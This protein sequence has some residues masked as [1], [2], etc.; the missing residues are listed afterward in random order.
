MISNKIKNINKKNI[1]IAF[2]IIV[3]TLISYIHIKNNYLQIFK[4]HNEKNSQVIS[5]KSGDSIRR[6]LSFD[7]GDIVEKIYVFPLENKNSNNITIRVHDN[8]KE[9]FKREYHTWP[10]NQIIVNTELRKCKELFIEIENNGNNDIDLYSIENNGSKTFSITSYLKVP[11]IIKNIVIISLVVICIFVIYLL[12]NVN[13]KSAEKIFLTI[14]IPFGL[15]YMLF[16]PP[17]TVP[18]EEAHIRNTLKYSS[19]LVGKG[20]EENLVVRNSEAYTGAIRPSIKSIEKFL[21]IN[22]LFDVNSEYIET[23]ID[24]GE[25]FKMITYLPGIIGVTLAR[26]ISLNGLLTIYIGRIFNFIFY[27]LCTY[28]AIKKI[29]IFKNLMLYISVLPMSIHQAISLSYDTSILALS[30]L[31]IGYGIDFLYGFG[32][33]EKK[34]II[35]YIITSCLLTFQKNG[36]YILLIFIPIFI[37]NRRIKNVKDRILLKIILLMPAI[38]CFLAPN[39]F[40]LLCNSTSSIK[41]ID[42]LNGTKTYDL[43]FFISNKTEAIKL[44]LKTLY[45]KGN[46]YFFSTFGKYLG[47]LNVYLNDILFLIW[48]I[49]G[50][51]STYGIDKKE[52]TSLINIKNYEKICCVVC[53]FAIV[54]LS[55]LAMATSFTPQGWPTIEGV[56]GRYFLPALPLL[57]IGMRSNY[58]TSTLKNKNKY[59]Y[60]L[61]IILHLCTIINIIQQ[62]LC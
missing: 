43:Q 44:F 49:L 45:L 12:C 16:F 48:P 55:M 37:S 38:L 14:I 21:N 35:I 25:G 23:G 60:L 1:F 32:E 31:I 41:T 20:T 40:N 57:F 3:V 61:L 59:I 56:Q 26:L 17:M 46:M 15:I 5:L 50:V 8:N 4:Y 54:F 29:P 36:F 11:E 34:D 62:C 52:A 53:F 10:S 22:N 19:I 58:F 24:M 9:Y 47:S 7:E 39:V 30:W 13:K 27:I 28:F 18:D 51:M 33:I 6:K 42:N 2:F